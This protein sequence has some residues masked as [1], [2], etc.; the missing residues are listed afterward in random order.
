MLLSVHHRTTGRVRFGNDSSGR[1]QT[2]EI[3]I[4]RKRCWLKMH[5][6]IFIRGSMFA[7]ARNTSAMNDIAVD[8]KNYVEALFAIHRVCVCGATITFL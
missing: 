5:I 6:D 2:N 3:E 7:P 1:D 4:S 8:S